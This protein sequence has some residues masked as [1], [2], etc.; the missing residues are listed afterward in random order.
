MKTRKRILLLVV[1]VVLVM[2][3]AG[4]GGDVEQM[5]RRECRRMGMMIHPWDRE[6]RREWVAECVEGW[7]LDRA[8]QW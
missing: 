5:G 4:C 8:A 1:L 7:N 2:T 6:A 3:V